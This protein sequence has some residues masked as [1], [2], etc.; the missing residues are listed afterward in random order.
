MKK[1]ASDAEL[2]DEQTSEAAINRTLA[3]S[4]PASD[5]PCWTLGVKMP[6]RKRA[7]VPSGTRGI[8]AP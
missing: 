6:K 2:Q 4:F 3:D 8:P 1:D 5:P 7:P